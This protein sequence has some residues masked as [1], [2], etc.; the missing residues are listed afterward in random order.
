M[1]SRTIACR[2]IAHDQRSFKAVEQATDGRSD[3]C[4]GVRATVVRDGLAR[5][6]RQWRAG[7]EE[8]RKPTTARRRWMHVDDSGGQPHVP[9]Q[10]PVCAGLPVSLSVW[11]ECEYGT[12]AKS[13]SLPVV[14]CSCHMTKPAMC[15]A[16]RARARNKRKIHQSRQRATPSKVRTSAQTPFVVADGEGEIA[17]WATQ[18][19]VPCLRQGSTWARGAAY[20][21]RNC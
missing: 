6:G 17:L 18:P 4:A 14:A 16:G 10:P 5:D 8:G 3:K 12:A 11:V 20:W 2:V 15:G 21:W 19:A 7:K 9:M 13:C 1:H